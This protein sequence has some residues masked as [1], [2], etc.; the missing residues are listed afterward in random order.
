MDE[1]TP[2]RDLARGAHVGD[3]AHVREDARR[4]LIAA[5][6]SGSPGPRTRRVLLPRFTVGGGLLL[7]PV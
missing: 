3:E 1:L 5:I 7:S 4:A 2:L 6:S